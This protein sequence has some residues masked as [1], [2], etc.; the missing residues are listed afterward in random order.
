MDLNQVTVPVTDLAR[1]VTFYK[2]L[3]LK[4]IVLG[5]KDHYDV[6]N[7]RAAARSRC[8]LCPISAATVTL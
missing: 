1:A 8:M 5:T 4:P 3:G 7:V 6:L 2:L